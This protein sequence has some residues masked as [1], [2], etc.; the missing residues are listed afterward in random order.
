M[1]TIVN[2]NRLFINHHLQISPIITYTT[3]TQTP[4]TATLAHH[5]Y[6]S[7]HSNALLAPA[8]R[9]APYAGR[10]AASRFA[11][12]AAVLTEQMT[13]KQNAKY[14]KIQVGDCET[15]ITTKVTKH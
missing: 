4:H 7:R 15:W 3:Y 8:S 10:T 6:T 1:N 13:L 9:F 2:V 14:G 12:Y 11:P 5:D